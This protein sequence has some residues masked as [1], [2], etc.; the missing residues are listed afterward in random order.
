MY[1]ELEKLWVYPKKRK[2]K[3]LGNFVFEAIQRTHLLT[4]K[5]S[6]KPKIKTLQ[7]KMPKMASRHP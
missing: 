4:P 3:N 5:R 1:C 2:K 7:P 6:S